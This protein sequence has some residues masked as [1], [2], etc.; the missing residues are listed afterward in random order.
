MIS[1]WHLMNV[2]SQ[3]CS[4]INFANLHNSHVPSRFSRTLTQTVTATSPGMNLN[5]SGTTSLTSASSENWTRTSE[6]FQLCLCSQIDQFFFK[7]G[8][9]L[10][11]SSN[12]DGKISR[13]EMTEYFMKA[14]SLLN[15]KMGFIH[16]FTE[17]TY[18]KP[19]FCE[20]CAGF[21]SKHSLVTPPGLAIT[22]K[23]CAFVTLK[24]HFEYKI[25]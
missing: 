22:Q 12:R 17:T 13:E 20:H 9:S 16:T 8:S 3:H 24:G 18:V 14:S 25:I 1:Q 10:C 5:Q 19:T 6:R 23:C 2:N 7:L 4:I 15:C 11:L 21:V